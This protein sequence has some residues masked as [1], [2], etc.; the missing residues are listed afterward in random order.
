MKPNISMMN[1]FIRLTAGFTLLA[2]ST[3][4]LSKEESTSAWVIA[5][6]GAMKVA[7]G[8]TRYCPVVDLMTQDETRDPDETALER[9]INPS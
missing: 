4:K 6:I 3:A 8:H 9:V 1:A 5:A 7:E 2:Y